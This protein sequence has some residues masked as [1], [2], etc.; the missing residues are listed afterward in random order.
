MGRASDLSQAL[1]GATFLLQQSGLPQQIVGRQLYKNAGKVREQTREAA[2]ELHNR[3]VEQYQKDIAEGF[4]PEE[5][6]KFGESAGEEIASLRRQADE[7]YASDIE[8]IGG[9]E[10]EAA[11]VRARMAKRD[12]AKKNYQERMLPELMEKQEEALTAKK[13]AEEV[14]RLILE[15]TYRKGERL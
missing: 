6:K 13:N 3:K 9:H 5:A 1:T 2:F 12:Y 10:T 15:G 11:Q 4:S 7:K 14:R 8:K